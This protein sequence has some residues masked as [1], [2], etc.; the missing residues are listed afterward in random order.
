MMHG[1]CKIG[2]N[3]HS[4]S[5]LERTSRI[6]SVELMKFLLMQLLSFGDG[7]IAHDENIVSNDVY[8]W[9]CAVSPYCLEHRTA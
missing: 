3:F 5:L 6:K 8:V 2:A 4:F 9:Q 7:V 1:G